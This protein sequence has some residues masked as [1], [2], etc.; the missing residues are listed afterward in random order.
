VVHFGVSRRIGGAAG[1]GYSSRIAWARRDFSADGVSKA[2][3]MGV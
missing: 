1:R 2:H 3:L